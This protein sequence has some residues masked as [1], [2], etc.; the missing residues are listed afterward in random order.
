M[1]TSHSSTTTMNNYLSKPWLPNSYSASPIF[2]LLFP[3]QSFFANANFCCN[4]LQSC[5]P[6]FKFLSS[7]T[8]LIRLWFS[9]STFVCLDPTWCM[10]LKLKSWRLLIHLPLLPYASK[11]VT[12]HSDGLWDYYQNGVQFTSLNH[13]GTLKVK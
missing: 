2:E 6:F 10:I 3:I 8:T 11:I 5:I 7:S 9:A 1:F 12:N 4:D 13:Y